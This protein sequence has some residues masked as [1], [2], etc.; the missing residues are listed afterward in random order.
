MEEYVEANSANLAGVTQAF[1]GSGANAV[2]GANAAAGASVA[3]VANAPA[4]A[5]AATG[6]IVASARGLGLKTPL[7]CP[8]SGID[9]DIAQGQ[10][11]VLRGRSGTGKTALLLTIA[12]RMLPTKG[13][14]RVL[15]SKL[16]FG[17]RKVQK[18]V[19]L[20]FFEGLNE[21]DDAQ[22][23][24]RAVAAEFELH[25]RKAEKAAVAQYLAD[26]RLAEV[27]D[28]RVSELDEVVFSLSYLLRLPHLFP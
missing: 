19:G 7:G 14:I 8:Y 15:G 5:N 26:W 24:Q 18:Q 27:A 3:A 4:A 21:L 16:P 1:A 9:F 11:F 23:V 20:A 22:R 25:G 17:A 13:K 28:K 6:E 12:G 2:A 10:V